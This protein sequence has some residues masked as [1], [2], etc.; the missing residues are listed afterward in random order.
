MREPIERKR[1]E[2]L[3][4]GELAELAIADA[5]TDVF[6]G[7]IILH[8]FRW[9]ASQA[10][11]GYWVLPDGARAEASR[12]GRASLLARWAI[13]ELG[14]TRIE[15]SVPIDNEA[16]LRSIERGGFTQEGRG[17]GVFDNQR[18]RV[19]LARY[20]FVRAD[21]A[22]RRRRPRVVDCHVRA[23]GYSARR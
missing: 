16:S 12:H 2:Q 21:L 19:D 7:S 14:L 17:E 3:R 6:L 18:D 5:K 13:E 4:I 23:V 9:W 1:P 8:G 11:I 15:A 10:E 20:S 22:P